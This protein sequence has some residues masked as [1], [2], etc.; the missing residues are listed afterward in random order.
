MGFVEAATL[1]LALLP[2]WGW[3]VLVLTAPLWGPLLFG[4]LLA[5]WRAALQGAGLSVLLLVGLFLVFTRW[6]GL[7]S[8]PW[9]FVLLP[10]GG[11]VLGIGWVY[12][13]AWLKGRERRQRYQ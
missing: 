7:V 4:V 2:W 9:K 3:A 13:Q 5:F 6:I 10:L 8:W 11:A 1:N 12:L